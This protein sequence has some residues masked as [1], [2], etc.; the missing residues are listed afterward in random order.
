[1]VSLRSN[2]PDTDAY[3]TVKDSQDELDSLID[4]ANR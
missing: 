3:D 4:K 2:N 1:M